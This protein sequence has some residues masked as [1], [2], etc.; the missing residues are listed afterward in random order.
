MICSDDQKVA[1]IFIV[2]FDTIEPKLALA[3]PK[4]VILATNGIEARS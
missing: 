2:Y 3:I 1:N 4:D